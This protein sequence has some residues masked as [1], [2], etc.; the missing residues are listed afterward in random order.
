MKTSVIIEAAMWAM[1][2]LW[3]IGDVLATQVPLVSRRKV[4]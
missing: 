2:A 1:G 4:A 3:P